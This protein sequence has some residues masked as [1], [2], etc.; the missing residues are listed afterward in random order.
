MRTSSKRIYGGA[1]LLSAAILTFH[2]GEFPTLAADHLD[3]PQ[4]TDP[5]VDDTPD[6]AADIADIYTFFDDQTT[7]LI[8]TFAGPVPTDAAATFDPDVRYYINVSTQEPRTES[9]TR[10]QIQFGEDAVQ[11]GDQFG[12]RVSGLPGVTGDIIGPV[13]TDLE[14][15]G[16][17]VRAGLYDD[18]FFFDLQGFRETLDTGDLSF[19]SSRDFFA[20]QN[21]TAVVIEIPN[22][23][24]SNGNNVID[25]WTETLRLGGQL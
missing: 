11:P 6:R 15:Q 1:A 18:P 3:P 17:K 19:D 12:I 2:L 5:S 22:A 24:I 25:V 10:I 16:V 14:E 9:N 23:N 20:G 8:L 21:I 13:E 4:R 7:K